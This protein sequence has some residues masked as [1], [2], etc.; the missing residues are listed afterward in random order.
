ME[1]SMVAKKTPVATRK[2]TSHFGLVDVIKAFA[3]RVVQ[4]LWGVG[5]MILG[6]VFLGSAG[7]F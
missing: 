7:F 3:G 6:G 2:K 5:L 4:S 1:E